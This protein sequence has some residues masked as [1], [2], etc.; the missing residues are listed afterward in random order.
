MI[1][2]S[3]QSS[4]TKVQE[5]TTP[6]HSNP[7]ETTMW[8]DPYGV[9]IIAPPPP[10]VRKSR[11]VFV[12]TVLSIVL[13]TII[14]AMGG[15][16]L[17][18]GHPVRIQQSVS[19]TMLS[20]THVKT[21][22]KAPVVASVPTVVPTSVPTQAPAQ[23]IPTQ[24]VPTPMPTVAPTQPP[25]P[26][27]PAVDAQSAYNYI[28]SQ[29]DPNHSVSMKGGTGSW[30]GWPYMPEHGALVWTDTTPDGTYSVLVAVFNSSSEAQTD[31]Q[32]QYND[33]CSW[34]SLQVIQCK[35][36]TVESACIWTITTVV[37]VVHIL[38]IWLTKY[39]HST[40]CQGAVRR[41]HMSKLK[42]DAQETIS[43][44]IGVATI[45]IIVAA[46]YSVK[47]HLRH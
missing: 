17:L 33:Q 41:S 16:V 21:H 36:H 37:V 12:I 18:H 11:L 40:M 42:K 39:W 19:S 10:T 38:A 24:V 9:P 7:Y 14:S 26:P 15:Y 34:T 28:V 45:G 22:T 23:I 32:C 4:A 3:T 31:Y 8:S 2:T 25:A 27:I 35:E 6:S 43:F 5:P 1:Q 29:L 30:N 46:V 13:V 20:P 44:L 47:K